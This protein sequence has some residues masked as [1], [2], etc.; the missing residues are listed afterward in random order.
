MRIALAFAFAFVGCGSGAK[1]CPDATIMS[2]CAS[3]MT[4]KPCHD[5][6]GNVC[7]VCAGS[8][9]KAGCIY[10]PNAPL[11]GGTAVCVNKCGD[12]GSDCTVNG[13]PT[14]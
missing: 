3:M 9:A 1:L 5:V 4:R 2:T 11:D 10:D 8:G 6:H 12:C 7:I 13:D 14:M